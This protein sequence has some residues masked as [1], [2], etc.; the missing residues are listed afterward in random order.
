[1]WKIGP[2]LKMAESPLKHS[3]I[4][5]L[6]A[7]NRLRLLVVAVGN[8]RISMGDSMNPRFPTR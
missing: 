5:P 2:T 7:K 6:I 1:M 3:V 4:G 8:N